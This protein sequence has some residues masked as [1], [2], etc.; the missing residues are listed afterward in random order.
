MLRFPDG[1]SDKIM[2][3]NT[4]SHVL[5]EISYT[6][7]DGFKIVV[8]IADSRNAVDPGMDTGISRLDI[9]RITPS[10]LSDRDFYSEWPINI[11]LQGTY[12]LALLGMGLVTVGGRAWRRRRA[13]R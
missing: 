13:V 5:A 4:R 8:G 12:Q 7:P 11:H 10:N 2:A 9:L 1:A 6:G 3:R